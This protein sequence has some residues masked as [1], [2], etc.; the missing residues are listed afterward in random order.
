MKKGC[1]INADC[2]EDY[3]V[4]PEDLP[5]Y[6]VPPL[7]EPVGGTAVSNLNKFSPRQIDVNKS[8]NKINEIVENDR[9]F[10]PDED[11]GER[12]LFDFINNMLAK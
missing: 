4:K 10:G 8:N 7:V 1:L 6:Q 5:E 9:F 12:N 2:S 11:N 3:L